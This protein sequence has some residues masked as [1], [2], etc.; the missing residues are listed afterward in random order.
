MLFFDTIKRVSNFIKTSYD[1]ER[2]RCQ[3]CGM[4]LMFDKNPVKSGTYCSY[5]HNGTDFVNIFI[6]RKE[7]TEKIDNILKKR[8]TPYYI[9]LYIKIRI[10]TLKRWIFKTSP[11]K[12]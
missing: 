4:P 7:M 2:N 10:A 9:R 5:C 11:K 6:S 1:K 8:N 3:S 12:S